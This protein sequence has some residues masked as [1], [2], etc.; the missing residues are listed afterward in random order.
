MALG[1]VI[2]SLDSLQGR[3]SIESK[4]NEGTVVTCFIPIIRKQIKEVNE[5]R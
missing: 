4:E 1:C 3:L 2:F 5:S